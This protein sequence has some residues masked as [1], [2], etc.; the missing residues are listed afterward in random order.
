MFGGFRVD[1]GLVNSCREDAIYMQKY[2]IN[3]MLDCGVIDDT[4][5]EYMD[6]CL[7]LLGGWCI[8]LTI[9]VIAGIIF[10]CSVG[11]LFFVIFYSMLRC[12]VGGIHCKKHLNCYLISTIITLVVAYVGT[13]EFDNRYI[14]EITAFSLVM[15]LI[16]GAVNHP[17]LDWSDEELQRA[18][19]RARLISTFEASLIILLMS[20]GLGLN[21]VLLVLARIIRKEGSR[22]E[23][24][25]SKNDS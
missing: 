12:Y 2:I 23:T 20:L 11:M 25:Y 15:V 10:R 9:T 4:E 5:K 1:S 14:F 13:K 7:A 22:F 24:N 17:D 8:F 18:K 16:F 21:A 19:N 3:K 6:Y